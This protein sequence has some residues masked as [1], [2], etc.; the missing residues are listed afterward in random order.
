LFPVNR[1]FAIL[2]WQFAGFLFRSEI[3]LDPLSGQQRRGAAEF[4][5]KQPGN[6]VVNP[7]LSGEPNECTRTSLKT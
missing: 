6:G 1:G 3:I 7:G 5:C 4:S 2:L